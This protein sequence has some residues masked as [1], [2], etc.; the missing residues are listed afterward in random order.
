MRNS[1]GKHLDNFVFFLYFHSPKQ[2][3]EAVMY[4]VGPF[5]FKIFQQKG[6]DRRKVTEQ[7]WKQRLDKAR[8]WNSGC[9]PGALLWTGA[10]F[11]LP[12]DSGNPE[13]KPNASYD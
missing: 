7:Y 3:E 9:N 2:T 12:G 8:T 6:R 1:L 11:Q 13:W 4:S 5:P 10:A